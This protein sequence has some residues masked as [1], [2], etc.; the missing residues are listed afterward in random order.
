MLELFIYLQK[1]VFE[2][3]GHIVI[4]TSIVFLLAPAFII[5]FIIVYNQRKKKHIEEKTKLQQNFNLELIRAQHEIQ[6]QTMQTIGADLHDNIGQ[7]LSLTSLTL[8]SIELENKKKAMEKIEAS[9][10]LTL[11]SIKE[12]RMLGKLLQGDQLVAHGLPEAIRHEISWIEKAGKY[13]INYLEDGE[14]PAANN[15]DKDL[16]IFR[17]IQEILNNIMKHAQAN[18]IDI[19]LSYV[20]KKLFI[21]I[22]DNGI[23]F[24]VNNLLK[25]QLGMG[26]Q[27]I[28]KRI[29]IIGG[30]VAFN[31]NPGNGTSVSINITYP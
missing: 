4:I 22:S 10:A 13:Q 18:Q 17:V 8:N 7:L 27:N 29:S 28:K 6:E 19:E 12:M 2:G 24:D 15:L 1:M 23:G 9:I 26:L 31:S 21:Q 3:I 25:E 14:L 30:E 5:V 16:I 11:R 20:D